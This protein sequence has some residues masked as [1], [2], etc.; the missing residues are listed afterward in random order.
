MKRL[1]PFVSL[2]ALLLGACASN[3]PPR[4]DARN[5]P[6]ASGKEYNGQ[7][8]RAM[9]L[10]AEG[11]LAP[12]AL[13]GDLGAIMAKRA[14][15]L[16]PPA[17][18]AQTGPGHT[19]VPPQVVKTV[20]P[21]YPLIYRVVATEAEVWLAFV[22]DTEGN[23]TDIRSLTDFD[24]AF[25]TASFEAVKQWKFKPGMVDGTPVNTLITIPLRF[26][27]TK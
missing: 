19:R 23:V 17:L 20:P 13:A 9:Q 3:P 16:Y 4:P 5:R 26:Y 14:E 12:N 25:V 15:A 11:K 8:N 10:E 21:V 7:A 1:Q 2:L 27:L 6:P 22:V 24:S 18:S